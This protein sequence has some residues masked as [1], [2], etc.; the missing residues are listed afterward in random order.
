MAENGAPPV[1][2]V[3]I[4]M[5]Q[6]KVKA[7]KKYGPD[8]WQPGGNPAYDIIDYAIN[9]VVGLHRYAEMIQN[10]VDAHEDWPEETRANIRHLAYRMR[11]FSLNEG[12][13]LIME[14]NALLEAKVELG[15]VE[16][17]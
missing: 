11:M 15:E 14:R 3:Q 17:R 13:R 4:R 1:D 10:R 7:L 6:E 2:S 9:E 12:A 5:N 16:I 8:A